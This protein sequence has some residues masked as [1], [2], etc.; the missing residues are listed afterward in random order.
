MLTVS[1]PVELEERL[2]AV[3]RKAG[4]NTHDIALEAILE[5]IQDLEDGF[6]ALER[7][8]SG[9]AEFYTL[10]EVRERLGLTN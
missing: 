3:A 1:L 5:E 2:E 9:D 6:L 7:M 4:R 10:E 8:K